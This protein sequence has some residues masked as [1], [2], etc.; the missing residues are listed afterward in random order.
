MNEDTFGKHFSIFFTDSKEDAIY[1]IPWYVKLYI[2]VLVLPAEFT[3]KCH[4]WKLA[5]Y[6][7]YF[8]NVVFGDN[9]CNQMLQCVTG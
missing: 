3:L 8:E 4:L 9:T 6:K 1:L 5:F 7:Y 2:F